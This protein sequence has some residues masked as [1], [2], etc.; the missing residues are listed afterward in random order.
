MKTSQFANRLGNQW[1]LIFIFIELFFFSVTSRGFFSIDA[2]QMILFYGTEVFLLGIAELFVI[3]TGGIDLSV[4]F[5]MGFSTVIASKLMVAFGNAGLPPWESVVVS[6]VITIGIGLLPGLVNGALVAYLRVPPFIAT[7]SMLG[8]TRGI[9]ELLLAGLP[10]KNL[11]AL[12]GD[13]G[14]GYLLYITK[15]PVISFITRPQVARGQPVQ[16]LIP[17]IVVISFVFILIFAFILRRTRFG[18]HIYAIGGNIDAAIRAGINVK[19]KLIQVYM[20][21]SLFATLAGLA[22]TFKYITGKADAGSGMLLSAIA[23]VVIGGASMNGGSGTVGRTILGCLVIAI[24]ETGLRIMN[25]QTFTT[26]VVVGLI[27]ILAVIVDQSLLSKN[28]SEG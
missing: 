6:S 11:P 3:I 2:M 25:L 17:L 13:L 9:S 10:A 28:H 22:Y 23:A 19:R 1:V 14:N 21:S 7:F 16:A 5:V 4:G 27:L 8:I 20:I 26:Y 12:A 18:Q 24:L 15:G